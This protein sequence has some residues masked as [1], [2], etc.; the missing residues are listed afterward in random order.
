MGLGKHALV[1]GADFV[2]C[3]RGSSRHFCKK[4]MLPRGSVKVG[5]LGYCPG[6]SYSTAGN[7]VV[8]SVDKPARPEHAVIST[9]DLFSI[10]VGPSSS[11]TVGKRLISHCRQAARLKSTYR[12]YASPVVFL[13]QIYRNTAYCTKSRM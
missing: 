1:L 4:Q 2:Q 13:W 10:G 8:T 12:T 7:A 6:R 9:F 3:T 11:H 5:P